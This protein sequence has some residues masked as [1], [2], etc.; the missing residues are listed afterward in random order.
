MLSNLEGSINLLIRNYLQPLWLYRSFIIGTVKREF[1]AKY[2]SSMLGA[3][4]L[5][6]NPMAMITVYTVI[7]SQIMHARMP[8]VDS[9]YGYSIF[10]C[11]GILSWGLFSEVVTRC[12]T[13]FL[14][15]ANIIKKLSFPRLCLPLAVTATA[16]LNF[17]IVL[18]IFFVF[19]ILSGNLPNWPLVSLFPLLALVVSFALGLGILLGVLSVFFRD[20]GQLFGILITF[21]FW[22]TP[23]VYPANIVPENVRKILE[24]N[25]LAAPMR[26]IQNVFVHNLWPDW[27]SLL[28]FSMISIVFCFLGLWVFRKLSG[29]MVDE[30]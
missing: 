30:L 7:F 8:G 2:R 28:P 10:L 18:S 6:I 21:W 27:G 5:I 14:D 13:M 3:T 24:V 25:P 11:A 26:A 23:I 15:N 1:Q 20:I 9:I 29:D 19:L 12:Q 17:S 16:L 4:W 22:L